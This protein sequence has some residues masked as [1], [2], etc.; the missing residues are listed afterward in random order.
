MLHQQLKKTIQELLGLQETW[1]EIKQNFSLVN[2]E[3]KLSSSSMS[4]G[5]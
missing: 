3:E 5:Y 4:N 1:L 2:Y